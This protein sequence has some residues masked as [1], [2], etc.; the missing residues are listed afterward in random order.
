MI[1]EKDKPADYTVLHP[2]R[3]GLLGGTFNPIHIGT[4]DHGGRGLQTPPFIKGNLYT[5]YIP[6]HKY[7][8]I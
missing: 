4:F 8:M 1:N 7:M 2:E 3:I 6:P 5:T